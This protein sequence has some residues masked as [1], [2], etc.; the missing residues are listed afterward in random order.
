MGGWSAL[1]SC[2]PS[3]PADYSSGSG[4]PGCLHSRQAAFPVWEVEEIRPLTSSKTCGNSVSRNRSTRSQNMWRRRC[5][6]SRVRKVRRAP[7]RFRCSKWLAVQAADIRFRCGDRQLRAHSRPIADVL[8]SQR[9]NPLHCRN[10][11]AAW[12]K[13]MRTFRRSAA[14]FRWAM[15]GARDFL[16]FATYAPPVLRLRRCRKE[17]R[18]PTFAATSTKVQHAF[19]SRRGVTGDT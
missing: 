7:V 6:R 15:P 12:Q 13:K 17:R 5:K 1:C 19:R 2:H 9:D 4:R 3:L 18:E 14:M 16:P 11:P 8:H 10:L